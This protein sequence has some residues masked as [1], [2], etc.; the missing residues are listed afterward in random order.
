MDEMTS[1]AAVPES[2]PEP[3][4]HGPV[5]WLKNNLF[6]GP[7]NTALTLFLTP[8]ILLSIRGVLGWAVDPLRKW[9]AVTTN[10]RLLSVQAYPEAHFIRVW[11]AVGIVA[12]LAGL[13]AAAWGLGGRMSV[14]RIAKGMKVAGSIFLGVALLT[15]GLFTDFGS[16]RLWLIVLGVGLAGGGFAWAAALGMR[17]KDVRI[18]TM[19]VIGLLLLALI[20]F[21][22]IV[23]LPVSNVL[24][25]GERVITYEPL[26]NSTKLPW[27]M[28]I[29]ILAAAYLVGTMI[30][31][32]VPNLQRVLSILWFLSFPFTLMIVM[33]APDIEWDKVVAI[34]LPIFL[35]VGVI[36][37]VAFYWM[38]N[39]STG[40]AGRI[41][42]ALWLIGI[43]LWM[44]QS[45]RIDVP[46]ALDFTVVLLF[47]AA[48]FL[49]ALFAIAAPSFGGPRAARLRYLGMWWSALFLLV[50]AFRLGEARSILELGGASFVG[51]LAL[52]FTLAIA[53]IGLSFPL[54]ILLALGRSSTMP[55]IRTIS[56]GYI[57]LVRSVPLITWLFVGSNLLP[58][59]LP[60]EVELDQVVRAIAAI[61]LFSAAY[62][63]ENVRGGLQ[64]IPKG[65]YEAADAVGM[66]TVQKIS[67]ITMPQALRAVIP[68]L[69]GQ[70][71]A[72]FK[73]TS[74][75]AIIGLFDLLYIAR[76]V[77]PGQSANL[78]S[79]M[80]TTVTA[81]VVYWVFTFSFSRASMRLE[82]RLGLGE[83]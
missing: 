37:S 49:G 7:L 13:S 29:V 62:L 69:V 74:L 68:A 53:G 19:S 4:P 34:D 54:G 59:F 10:A 31:S 48:V 27:T 33:R 18:P 71:I 12:T 77:I 76:S 55:I 21:L 32:A 28:I 40:E 43:V 75:V 22:W 15:P 20:G 50:V 30:R 26:A 72:L 1:V 6:S 14:R 63:A 39:P 66:S 81:A 82:K 38:G 51:G 83:R 8:V 2:P 44:W 11:I 57:E 41:V 45:W 70:V 9:P 65:Q 56:T 23:Q 35:L 25:E 17:A 42:A 52:T 64:S 47:K 24:V 78:G 16:L 73:D 5:L 67:L 3:P 79:I 80:V 60:A 46:A 36:G 58:L 61:A